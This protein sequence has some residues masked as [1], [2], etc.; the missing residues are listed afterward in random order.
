MEFV[1]GQYNEMRTKNNEGSPP[2]NENG[3]KEPKKEEKGEK[4]EE[5]KRKKEEKDPKEEKK[6]P[7]EEKKEAE[8]LKDPREQSFYSDS[9]SGES[10]PQDS[11]AGIEPN[12]PKTETM[13]FE[14]AVEE[15][16]LG[17]SDQFEGSG[18]GPVSS[19]RKGSIRQP[20]EHEMRAARQLPPSE[21]QENRS[22][23][24]KN[25]NILDL[26]NEKEEDKPKNQP[27]NLKD[28][29]KQSIFTKPTPENSRNLEVP[30]GYKDL[31]DA[32]M[33]LID[34]LLGGLVDQI[35]ADYSDKINNFEDIY[36]QILES[37]SSKCQHL[38]TGL[39]CKNKKQ[40]REHLG[41]KE[42]MNSNQEKAWELLQK[43]LESMQETELTEI[44][45]E[46]AMGFCNL[47]L[48]IPEL[49][50]NTGRL[51]LHLTFPY[52]SIK[53]PKLRKTFEMS[54]NA[55]L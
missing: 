18:G 45:E 17:K 44:T 13:T 51:I 2:E 4:K 22:E 40:W 36:Y 37:V 31:S 1:L 49:S 5:N 39:I 7:K 28:K 19:S 26:L 21:P 29:R 53:D 42:D 34:Q 48:R 16:K 55:N 52:R 9:Q 25:E 35:M 8:P 12:A 33:G 47:F 41:I 10:S 14:F 3:Q 38:M 23:V 30:K 11:S 6:D 15:E 43:S 46:D 32:L 24:K 54:E 27:L 20:A 50:T